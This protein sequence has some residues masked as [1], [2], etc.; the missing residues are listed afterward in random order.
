MT[1]RLIGQIHL[2]IGVALCAPLVALGL[3]GSLL[4][5]E[6]QWAGL[7]DPDP[8]ASRVAVAGEPRPVGEIPAAAQAAAPPGYAP[9]FYRTPAQEGGRA[10]VR[11]TPKS[12]DRQGPGDAVRIDV[13][14]VSLQV[15]A[16]LP[17]IRVVGFIHR[18]HA[19]F[20]LPDRQLVGWLGVAMV[21]L[22][23][24][25]LV[26]WWPPRRRWRDGFTVRRGATGQALYRQLHGAAGIWS[27]LVFIAVSLSG[28]YLAFPQTVRAGIDLVL[29]ARDLRAEV[30]G[31]KVAPLAD[32]TAMPVDE[33]IALARETVPGARV[34]LVGLAS[35]PDQPLR[36]TLLR[37]GQER[38]A[39]AVTVLVDPWAR[40][41]VKALDP[42]DFSAGEGIV[43]WQH[44]IHSGIGAGSVWKVLVFA[45]GF[46]PLLFSI[47]GVSMW[48]LK[49]GRRKAAAARPRAA[50]DQLSP[51]R[52]AAE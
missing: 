17:S 20:F 43:A 4:V 32:A 34:D 45:S 7:L 33:A 47:T 25:G 38:G 23:I 31:V 27:Y 24:S 28:V 46:L 13:D 40:R 49:R 30:N 50:P 42:H 5:L 26:N 41:V 3:S 21:A 11:L 35:R 36:V 29:P 37:P 6:D 39:P 48:W 8:A 51:A 15:F 22:G 16:D 52:R 14:P 12:R 9:A 44:A 1:R 10:S 18:L 2:W 19:D